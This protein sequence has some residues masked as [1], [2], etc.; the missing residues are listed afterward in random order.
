MVKLPYLDPAEWTLMTRAE[1]RAWGRQQISVRIGSEGGRPVWW[2]IP[3]AWH[4]PLPAD[5]D[6]TNVQVTRRRVGSHFRLAVAVSLRTAKPEECGPGRPAVAVNLG[7]RSLG[8]GSYRVATWTASGPLDLTWNEELA[9]W[10]LPSA[11]GTY[12]EVVIPTTFGFIDER[13]QGLQGLRDDKLNL[14]R[15]ELVSWL[16]EHP[17][18]AERLELSAANVARWRSAGRLAALILRWRETPFGDDDA[19]IRTHLEAWRKQD[20]H[21]WEWESNE[22]DQLIARRRDVYRKVAKLLADQ[23]GLLVVEASDLGQLARSPRADDADDVQSQKA[24]SQRTMAAPGMLRQCLEQAANKVGVPVVRADPA[25]IT[26]VHVRCGTDLAARGVD[27][28]A[29][30]RVWCPTCSE[31]VDQDYNACRQLLLRATA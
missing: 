28:A 15:A 25:G 8:D 5:A 9:P 7:W 24:R 14:I 20:K 18:L 22:R 17:E 12:G 3:V 1:Q 27:F 4:R 6:V 16:E 19:E 26:A 21:L 30:V 13:V 29:G 11:T 23:A 10:L 31:S 2:H